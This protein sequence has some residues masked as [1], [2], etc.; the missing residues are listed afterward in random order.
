MGALL[1]LNEMIY[2]NVAPDKTFKYD[3]VVRVDRIVER[4]EELFQMFWDQG[5]LPNYF[6]WNMDALLDSIF[7]WKTKL[8]KK[9]I[10]VDFVV[11]LATPSRTNKALYQCLRRQIEIWRDEDGVFDVYFR[12]DP[13]GDIRKKVE[14][15]GRVVTQAEWNERMSSRSKKHS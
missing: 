6:G 8:N 7:L 10:L 15:S 12:S 9:K 14:N 1:G 11:N 13:D 5:V 4:D 3:L 2:Y